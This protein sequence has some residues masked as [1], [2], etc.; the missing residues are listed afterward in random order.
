MSRNY[1]IFGRHISIVNLKG[2]SVPIILEL[3]FNIG[4]EDI[5]DKVVRFIKESGSSVG[6]RA[7]CPVPIWMSMSGSSLGSGSCPGSGLG[8]DHGL[9]VY[10]GCQSIIGS[11]LGRY[12]GWVHSQV[13]GLVSVFDPESCVCVESQG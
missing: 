4:W 9:G 3:A 6:S 7:R 8:S 10:V 2:R 5:T 1:N 12:Q 11:G 13:S